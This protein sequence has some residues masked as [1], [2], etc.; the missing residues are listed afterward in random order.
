[1]HH[2]NSAE[3]NLPRNITIVHNNGL[4]LNSVKQIVTIFTQS[5]LRNKEKQLQNN[6]FK[7]AFQGQRR[8]CT[9]NKNWKM[10]R[11][12]FN[13]KIKQHYIF[14]ITT[15]AVVRQFETYRASPLECTNI[16]TE[17]SMQRPL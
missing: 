12:T 11:L 4:N 6:N 3:H 1:M 15:S 17:I 10:P 13:N 2:S 7:K 14:M 5:I 16:D 9:H 8:I